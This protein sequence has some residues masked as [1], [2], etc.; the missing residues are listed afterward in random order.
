MSMSASE[1]RSEIKSLYEQ[2]ERIEK[3]YPDGEITD[4]E[5]LA[6]VKA[7]LSG[8]DDLEAKLATLE[9][10]ESRKARIMEGVNKY[11]LPAQ[12]IQHS[13]NG[14]GQTK[15][16]QPQRVS[17][18]QQFIS[19]S[20][21]RHMQSGGSFKSDLNR[22]VFAVQMKDGT[23]L[24]EWKALLRAVDRTTSGGSFVL[25][26]NRPGVLDL[27]QRELT[28]LDLI[29]RLGTESDTIQYIREDTFTNNAA[30]VAEA[31][32]TTGTTGTKPESVLQ[33]STQSATVKT[34]AHWI[35]ITNRLLDDAPAIRGIIDTRLLT[36]LDLVLE[37]QVL[38]GDGTGENFS[39]LLATGSGINA[40]GFSNNIIDS[41]FK[42]RTKVR[43]TGH[44]RPNAVVMH[45]NDYESVRLLREGTGGTAGAYLMGPPS[46]T[47][48]TTI[49]GMPVVESEAMTE[50]TALVGDFR[51]GISLFDREM[52]AI[53]VGTINDQF[54]RN[55]QTI[56]AE[57]RWALVIWRP[58]AFT[59]V[60]GI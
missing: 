55:M 44:A 50:N 1:A 40:Q 10:A 11:G 3:L 16:G 27:L 24:L 26:E 6:Q 35:P 2:A 17:P 45:P 54:V 34:L 15:G 4:N 23:S 43:V 60:T 46:E 8:I 31:T 13:S 57:G 48:P 47:G 20:E 33:Y 59:Q 14:Q 32:A 29:P 52:S 36:G 12:A 28:L 38:S 7:L 53:R 37:T 41:I 18:G 5:D 9:D 51:L 42:G 39:G 22:S 49:F 30:F 25:P 19:S 21:W 56:L 58:T